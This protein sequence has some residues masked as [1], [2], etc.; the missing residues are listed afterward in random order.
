MWIL[1]INI[2]EEE[3][4]LINTI[5]LVLFTLEECI[6]QIKL[7]QKATVLTGGELLKYNLEHWDTFESEK[8]A[9]E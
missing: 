1:T 7:Y 4:I 2:T 3:T 9:K 8:V 5:S 6:I